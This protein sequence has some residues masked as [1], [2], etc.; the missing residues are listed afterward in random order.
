MR[1]ESSEY[2]RIATG[3]FTTVGEFDK[4]WRDMLMSMHRKFGNFENADYVVDDVPSKVDCDDSEG[5][6]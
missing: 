2:V 6:S 4:L 3:F 5:V 1:S